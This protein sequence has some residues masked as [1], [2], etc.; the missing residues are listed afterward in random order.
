MSMDEYGYPDNWPRCTFC[1]LPAM[2]G[3]LTCGR[4]SCNESQ[5]RENRMSLTSSH[6]IDCICE[7]HPF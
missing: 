1:E 3:H 4:S 6:P 2:D 7:L 5:G